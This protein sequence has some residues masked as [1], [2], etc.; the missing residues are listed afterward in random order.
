MR[1]ARLP[2]G[3]EPARVFTTGY[4]G[5][6]PDDLRALVT[7]LGAV[8]FDIRFSPRSRVPRWEKGALVEL[9]GADYRHLPALG[10]TNYRER[11]EIRIADLEGG[12]AAVL[13]ETRPVVM[14]C[15]CEDPETCHRRT[16]ARALEAR[17]VVV[18]E[19]ARWD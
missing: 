17:G 10:N 12:L 9:L 15:A 14:L 2:F 3:D 7:R 13:E 11:A 18:E 16:V 4:T 5:K 19:I 8:L 6:R 1:D